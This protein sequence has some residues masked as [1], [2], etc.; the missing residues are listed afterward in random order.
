MAPC[1]IPTK[2]QNL[3]HFESELK[4]YKT[5]KA[6][7]Q[8]PNKKPLP[9]PSPRNNIWQKKNPWFAEQLLPILK[10]KIKESI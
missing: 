7:V 8:F 3:N 5:G 6:S 1:A 4:E 9:H 10:L 2:I